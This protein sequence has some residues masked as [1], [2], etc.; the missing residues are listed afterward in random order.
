MSAYAAN[1]PDAHGYDLE[2]EHFIQKRFTQASLRTFV[3]LLPRLEVQPCVIRK[4]KRGH[5]L[6]Y[7]EGE[8]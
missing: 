5:L 1:E 8:E 6:P 4:M 7:W 3:Q 2:A